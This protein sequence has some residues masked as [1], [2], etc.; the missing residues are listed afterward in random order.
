MFARTETA[1]EESERFLTDN[2]LMGN[3]VEAYLSQY[4]LISLCAEIQQ[5]IY[6]TVATH[7]S[8]SDASH[9]LDDYVSNSSKKILRSFEKNEIAGY[10]DH[11]GT[12]TKDA[13][14]EALTGCDQQIELYSGIVKSR[15]SVAHDGGCKKSFREIKAGLLAAEMIVNAVERALE[16]T[17]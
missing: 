15:H 14:N 6:S 2:Q 11:F 7:F 9:K 10:L 13:F 17:V 4:L 16:T 5:A 12:A 1:L 3:P 8:K